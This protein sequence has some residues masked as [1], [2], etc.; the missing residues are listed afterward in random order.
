MFYMVQEFYWHLRYQYFKYNT[1]VF[2]ASYVYLMY[3]KTSELLSF[4]IWVY[5]SNSLQVQQLIIINN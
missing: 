3:G 4:W 1:T 2:I 5:K